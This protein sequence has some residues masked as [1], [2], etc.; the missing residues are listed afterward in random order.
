M[1]GKINVFHIVSDK[2][3]S[4]PEQYA[5]DLSV[6]LRDDDRFYCEAVCKKSDSIYRKFRSLEIPV[7]MLPLKGLS[8]FDSPVR[9]ARLLKRG[10]NVIHVHTFHDAVMAIL[11]RTICNNP[12][13]K[14]VLT[15]HG[16]K[17]P[18]LNVVTRKVYREVDRIIFVS[19]RSCDDVM[20]LIKG[21]PAHKAQV[22]R[23]SVLPATAQMLN[24]APDL[25][26]Q[27]GIAPEKALLMFHGRLSADKGADVLLQAVAQL[28]PDTWHLVMLGEGQR[29]MVAQLKAFA[30]ANNMA[31]NISFLGFSPN[32]QALIKQC[33]LG[34]LPS[35]APEAMGIANLEYMM[36]GKAHI[37]TNNGAQT[38]YLANGK[39]ALLVDPGNHLQLAAA[40]EQLTADSAL[41]SQLGRQARADFDQ[42]LNYDTF[43]GHIT[44][45]YRSLFAKRG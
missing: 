27:L 34:V 17:R 45:L 25:R 5:Y 42:H 21:F 4:G 23:D 40:I 31:Q 14:I 16:V 1:A 22:I 12:K 11:A 28:P 38:E 32:V 35:T 10:E 2:I 43:Y 24:D 15:L 9:F 30:V 19:Q 37:A 6:R 33:D 13:I 8:D 39:N 3:W 41:R 26:Q 20:P 44:D 36:Q 18:R 29:K 7:S